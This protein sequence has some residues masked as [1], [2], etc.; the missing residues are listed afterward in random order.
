LPEKG[1]GK[2]VWH[3]WVQEI[4]WSLNKRPGNVLV[5]ALSEHF[6]FAVSRAGDKLTNE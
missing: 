4:L 1:K 6:R 3:E 5:C 2:G